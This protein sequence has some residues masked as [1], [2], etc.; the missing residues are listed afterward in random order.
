M[1]LCLLMVYVDANLMPSGKGKEWM[2]KIPIEKNSLAQ[3]GADKDQWQAGLAL[4]NVCLRKRAQVRSY[5][6]HWYI[7]ILFGGFKHEFYFPFHIWDV[8]L[9]LTNSY[10]SRWLK[11]P[12]IYIYNH[13]NYNMFSIYIYLSLSLSLIP[14]TITCTKPGARVPKLGSHGGVF[15]LGS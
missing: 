5:D 14:P 15:L 11:P 1:F 8:I 6:I 9:P 7:Y 4:E 10:F 12:T 2:H 3:A 13:I